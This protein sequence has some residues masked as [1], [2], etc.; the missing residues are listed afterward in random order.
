MLSKL[1]VRI[2]LDLDL[3]QTTLCGNKIN[4]SATELSINQDTNALEILG[5]TLFFLAHYR[6]RFGTS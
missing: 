5:G 2:S 4:V 6:K 1:A 3:A